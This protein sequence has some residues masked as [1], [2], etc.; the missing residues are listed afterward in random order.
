M[1]VAQQQALVLGSICLAAALVLAVV[2]ALTRASRF[3]VFAVTNFLLGAALFGTQVVFGFSGWRSEVLAASVVELP[4]VFLISWVCLAQVGGVAGGTNTSPSVPVIRRPR[5][6]QILGWAPVALLVPWVFAVVVGLMWP[7]AAMQPY[8]PAPVQ[9]LVFKWPMSISQTVYAGL[10]ATVFAMAAVSRASAPVLRLRN[11]AF[12][13]S[14]ASLALVGG[15]TT[16]TA[17]VRWWAGQARRREIVDALLVFETFL[18]VV[19]FA[20]LILGLALRYTPVVAAAVLR[21]V[22]TGWLPARERLESSGWQAVAGGRTRGIARVTY[23]LKEAAK[24]AGIS[25]PDADRALAAIELIA[26]MQD[27]STEKGGITPQAVR[28]L[29]EMESEIAQD[30]VLGPK[31]QAS[32]QRRIDADGPRSPYAAPLQDALKAALDL[33]DNRKCEAE[34]PPRPMWFQLVA[35]ASADSGLIDREHAVRQL[36]EQVDGSVAAEAYRA[37]KGRLRSQVFRRL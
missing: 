3:G 29:Y 22:H 2:L 9:F 16:L 37:A 23:R 36:G 32:L 7:S 19:C 11:A 28:E 10:A 13:V 14:M 27:P 18:A 8:A 6:R 25:Q 34:K 12:S 33:T 5:L 31:I 35:V 20:A 26:V 30:E 1:S 21:Q 24:L 17:G 4:A 15:E